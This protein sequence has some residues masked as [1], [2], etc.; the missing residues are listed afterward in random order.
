MLF[1]CSI[2]SAKSVDLEGMNN[3][4]VG[5]GTLICVAPGSLKITNY[6]S[7]KSTNG[8]AYEIL[9]RTWSS[10]SLHYIPGNDFK[11]CLSVEK[12]AISKTMWD[13]QTTGKRTLVFYARQQIKASQ[14]TV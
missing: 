8:M 7:K 12:L 14:K 5:I 1:H 13:I 4:K 10:V 3:I 11:A 9:F 6:Q 2:N